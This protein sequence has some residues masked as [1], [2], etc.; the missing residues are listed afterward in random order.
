[1]APTLNDDAIAQGLAR[2]HIPGRLERIPLEGA[3]AELWVDCAHNQDGAEALATAIATQRPGSAVHL[4]YGCLRDKPAEAVLARLPAD[5]LTVVTVEAGPRTREAADLLPL[6]RG[7]TAQAA[8]CASPIQAVEA[9]LRQAKE[10]DIV[11]VA[12][13]VYLAGAVLDG[14]RRGEIWPRR[15]PSAK[16]R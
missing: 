4:V 2:A 11:L 8:A 9:A 16:V 7:R 14:A 15:G 5:R 1:M 13:S 6:A 12:G 10:G 3:P